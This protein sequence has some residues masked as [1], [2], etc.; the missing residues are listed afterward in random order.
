[1]FCPMSR[2]R[3]VTSRPAPQW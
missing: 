2:I 1:M 3:P